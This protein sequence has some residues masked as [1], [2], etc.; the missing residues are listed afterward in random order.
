MEP[1]RYNVTNSLIGSISRIEASR[2]LIDNAV[3]IPLWERQFRDEAILRAVHH[4]THVEGNPLSMFQAQKIL[5]GQ[6]IPSIEEQFAQEIINYRE[7]MRYIE[8]VYQDHHKPITMETIRKMHQIVM[9]DILDAKSLGKFRLG[10]VVV[11]NNLNGEVVFTPPEATEVSDLMEACLKS[12][13]EQAADNVHPV[14]RA[15]IL[16]YQMVYIHP[17]VD[18][19]GRTARSLATLSLYKD[20]YDF[21]RFFC[22]DE[23]Y[24]A[25]PLNYY[26]A[27]KSADKGDLTDW[28]E[29][30][31]SGL[32][33][34]AERVKERVLKLSRDARLRKVVGQIALNPRQEEILLFVERNGRIS[35][36][37]WRTLFPDVSDDTILRDIKAL[38]SKK[39]LRKRGKTKSSFYEGV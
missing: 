24:D 25:D 16:H 34:E 18:G 39:M 35:N 19:N 1:F 27:L 37:D 7:A 3:L 23:Y 10:K 36:A 9:Q 31:G 2:S 22:M 28:L 11:R 15:G 26:Q 38:V 33:T 13:W 5:D 20:G 29:Y 4:S 30:F 21:K 6:N 8:E 12:L 17:F 32:A 14:I